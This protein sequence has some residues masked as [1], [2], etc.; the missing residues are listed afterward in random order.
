MEG[1]GKQLGK[2]SD[3]QAERALEERTQILQAVVA[4]SPVPIVVID[5]DTT[6]RLWNS[7][8]ERL[9][10]WSAEE[11]I[12]GLIKIVPLE[13]SDWS[14]CVR[15]AVIEGA[16]LQGVETYSTT[17]DG[18]RVDLLVSAA[19]LAHCTGSARAIVLLLEDITQ[20]KRAEAARQKTLRELTPLYDVGQGVADELDSQ[21]LLQTTTDTAALRSGGDAT[22]TIDNASVI[23]AERR[24]RNAAEAANRAKD[25]FLAVLGHELRNPLSAVRNGIVAARLDPARR[26]RALELAGRGA[27]HIRRLADDL[28]DVA[29]IAHGRITLRREAVP[30]AQIVEHAI[31]SSRQLIAERAHAI[32]VL[33]PESDLR[34][35]ADSIRLE[36]VIGNLLSNAAKYMN[37]GGQITVTVAHEGGEAVLRVRDTGI[38]IAPEMFPRVFDLFAQADQALDRA[39]GGLGIGLTLVKRLV[40]LHGG[41]VEAHSDGCGRGAEF[42][43]RLPALSTCGEAASPS[44]AS[45]LDGRPCARVLI[46]EDSADA[47]EMMAMLLEVL[48]HRVRAVGDGPSALAAA[49]ANPPDVMLIDIGLPGMDGYEV[50][51]QVRQHEGL[52]RVILVALTGYGGDEDRQRALAAGFD[53]HLAKPVDLDQFQGVVAQFATA[54]EQTTVH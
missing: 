5:P 46:V 28:L 51:R 54:P 22:V 21:R 31:E 53:Y 11:V 37:P 27:E 43:V 2:P 48:G 17:R 44:S 41:R 36:Q 12:G 19:P 9:F 39:Q 52:R 8:A 14:A 34:V 16:T 23:E 30:F 20:R 1:V 45:T 15:K 4:A 42:V 38:G 26:D 6:V 24:A 40:E 7:A 47:A 35:D 49:L 3:E 29:R 32:T 25:E 10:G 50:A 18:T 13:N 33:L